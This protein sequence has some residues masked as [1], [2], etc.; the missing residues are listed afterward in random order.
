MHSAHRRFCGRAGPAGRV[1]VQPLPL[2]QP[3]RDRA[4][5][6]AGRHPAWPWWASAPTTPTP[7][8]TTG[9]T[10]SPSRPRALA[11]RSRTWSTT[12]RT[13]AALS[14]PPARR[15]SS[16]T[17]RRRLAYRGAL[18]ESTPGNGE[19][20]TGELLGA[21]IELPGRPAGARAAPAE[22]GLLDQVA[23]LTPRLAAV[24]KQQ[25]RPVQ[26]RPRPASWLFAGQD[27]AE[28]HG[29]DG[30][31]PAP[32]PS[33]PPPATTCAIGSPAAATGKST[34]SCTSWPPSSGATP[35]PKDA[36]SLVLPWRAAR[37]GLKMGLVARR[38]RCS[39]AP[40]EAVT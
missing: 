34:A 40:L 12:T 14:A 25:E 8:R 36:P 23:V 24:R 22:H 3:R 13:S 5:H 19:P 4:G 31:G 35:P 38:R 21:A 32:H 11:G 17:T 1:L 30:H 10:S 37:S 20:V 28:R 16:S 18:D 7:T 33:T 2:R 9:R 15:T 6:V 29:H 39:M 27:F 26:L